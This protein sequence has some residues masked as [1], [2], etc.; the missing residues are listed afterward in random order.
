ME[1]FLRALFDIFMG[2]ASLVLAYL[3]LFN[4]FLLFGIL[5]YFI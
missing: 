2:I 4:A 1:T 3:H 5:W